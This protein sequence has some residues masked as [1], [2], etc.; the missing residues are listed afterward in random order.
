M[1]G[2]A[3][4][5]NDGLLIDIHAVG[6]GGTKFER[7]NGQ[8]AGAAAVV[9]YA[10]GSLDIFIEPLQ[11]QPGGGMT[12]CAESQ[13]GVEPQ[14]YGR[15]VG[16]IVP[17]GHNPQ[18]PGN[19]DGVKL[20]LREAHPILLR[21]LLDAVGRHFQPAFLGRGCHGG[22]YIALVVKQGNHQAALPNLAVFFARLAENSLFF[23]CAGIGIFYR[24]RQCAGG[25]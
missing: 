18:P 12:P 4:A 2:I 3:A 21:Q 20:R 25:H 14:V 23:V 5:G 24:G 9:E 15:L 10:V 6:G 13:A 11:A 1:L 22:G 16:N 8:N 19:T 7:G 17:S